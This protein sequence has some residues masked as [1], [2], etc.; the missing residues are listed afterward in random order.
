MNK[1]TGY[2]LGFLLVLAVVA[3]GFYVAYTGFQSSRAALLFQPTPAPRTSTP[4][5]RPTTAATSTSAPSTAQ[6]LTATLALTATVEPSVTPAG[7]GAQPANTAKPS[8][9][10][11]PPTATVPSASS[12]AFRLAG[13][14]APE[15]VGVCCYI[16][17]TVRDAAGT[18]LPDV[19]LQMTDEWGNVASAT[20]KAGAE[21]GVY[22][23]PLAI[24]QQ[25]LTFRIKIVDA[26]G[27]VISTQVEVTFDPAVAP[28]YRVDW[29]RNY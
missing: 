28:S 20:T 7:Q 10:P 12:F 25:A 1:G 15:A 11:A 18:G 23:F 5:P 27:T 8:V 29:K 21:A 14:P 6:V 9:T 19:V 16:R 13:P 26:Q 24:G 2:A 17:G 4:T 3:L 22:D